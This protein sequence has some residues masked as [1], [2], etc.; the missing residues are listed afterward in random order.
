MLNAPFLASIIPRK[1]CLDPLPRPCR[2]E[3]ASVLVYNAG[4]YRFMDFIRVGGLLT[5][6]IFVIVIVLVPLLWAI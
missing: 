2:I 5:V 4:R 3:P 1:T 6:V